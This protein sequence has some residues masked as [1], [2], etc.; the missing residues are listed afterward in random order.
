MQMAL[1]YFLIIEDNGLVKASECK[2]QGTEDYSPA[3]LLETSLFFC[4]FF[5]TTVPSNAISLQSVFN[6]ENLI[7]LV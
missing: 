7:T 3:A 5:S 4:V 6:G 2:Q 1:S